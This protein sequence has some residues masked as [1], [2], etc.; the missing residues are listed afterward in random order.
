MD[1]GF[2]QSPLFAV[3]GLTYLTSYDL[4]CNSYI[5]LTEDL[6]KELCLQSVARQT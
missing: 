5:V 6:A 2:G 4:T 3:G 1:G